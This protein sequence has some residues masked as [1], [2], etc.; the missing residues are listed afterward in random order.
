MIHAVPSST[1]FNHP[2]PHGT[3]INTVLSHTRW[4]LLYTWYYH[5]HASIIHCVLWSTRCSYIYGSIIDNLMPSTITRCDYP[6]VAIIHTVIPSTRFNDSHEYIVHT[7]LSSARC[8]S[9][10]RHNYPAVYLH[11]TMGCPDALTNTINAI[12]S[13]ALQVLCWSYFSRVLVSCMAVLRKKLHSRFLIFTLGVCV[14]NNEDR[15]NKILLHIS[16]ERKSYWE[17]IL[18]N[19]MRRWMIPEWK[20]NSVPYVQFIREYTLYIWS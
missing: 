8:M 6:P 13:T 1:R 3:I 4:V 2:P 15:C 10:P 7:V 5:Q 19:R 18:K 12:A 9:S 11:K 17:C 14:R 16:V 20:Y